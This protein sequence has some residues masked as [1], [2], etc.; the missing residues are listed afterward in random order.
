LDAA[1]AFQVVDKVSGCHFAHFPS[2]VVDGGECGLYQLADGIIIKPYDGY[3]PRYV[4]MVL[5]E[6]SHADGG[7][8]VIGYEGSIGALIHVEN[9]FGALDAG[10]FAEVA[11]HKQAFVEWDII[12]FERI[13]VSLESVRIDVARQA[14]TDMNDLFTTLVDEVP[15][16]LVAAFIIVDD[17]HRVITVGFYTIEEDNGDPLVR[18]WAEVIQGFCIEGK[19]SDEAVHSFMEQVFCVGHFP[20]IAL[21]GMGDDK[22]VTRGGSHF[23]D[24]GQYSVDKVALQLMDHKADGIG[25]LSPQAAGI[26]IGP[27]SHPFGS[28]KDLFLCFITDDGIIL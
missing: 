23:F 26:V 9:F 2:G 15:G 22:V 20:F 6:G 16:G 28:F 14:G 24:S 11:D 25:M 19:G 27:V 4:K 21:L 3:V 18:E 8:E 13:P 12:V 7:Y 5:L 10:L 17:D 1:N